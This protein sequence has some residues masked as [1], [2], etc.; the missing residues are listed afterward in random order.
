MT[1]IL[2]DHQ[3]LVW[4]FVVYVALAAFCFVKMRTRRRRVSEIVE[5]VKRRRVV[6]ERVDDDT[7]VRRRD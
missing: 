4:V 6:Y 3:L 5:R 2:S 7:F 1:I